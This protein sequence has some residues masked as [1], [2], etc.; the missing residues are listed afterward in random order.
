[1]KIK[2]KAFY[3]II[4]HIG[5]FPAERGGVLFGKEDD[6][7]IEEFIPDKS[8]NTTR[9][10]Y[11][12][13]TEYLNPIIKKMWDEKGYSML[14]ILHS[15]PHGYQTLSGPDRAYFKDL[16]TTGIKRDKFYAPVVF[17][18]PDGGFDIFPHL[19]NSSGEYLRTE[20]IVIIQSNSNEREARRTKK[21]IGF[22]RTFHRVLKTKS[23]R[24]NLLN[25]IKK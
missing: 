17:T 21:N 22:V 1:M 3:Q 8:K 7:I 9:V 13:D 4:N 10:T 19:L 18:I 12:I 20:E 16:L 2:S 24:N 6:F 11:T 5:H 23:K 15:H 14:G 25:K